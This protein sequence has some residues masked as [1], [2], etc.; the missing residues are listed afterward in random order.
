MKKHLNFNN[1]RQYIIQKGKQYK[2]KICMIY[3]HCCV[4]ILQL[5]YD[6]TSDRYYVRACDFKNAISQTS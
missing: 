3:F 2:S 1:F 5:G 4:T 6:Y